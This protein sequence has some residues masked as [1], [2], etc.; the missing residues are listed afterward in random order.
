MKELDV[1]LE[2]FARLAL[3]AASPAE[4]GAFERLL[5]LP[6]PQLAGYLL[7]D[8]RP[9]DPELTQL[10]DRIRDLSRARHDRPVC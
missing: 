9:G 3:P 5:G 1:V 8:D 2:R 10:T 6:D 4:R 7:G